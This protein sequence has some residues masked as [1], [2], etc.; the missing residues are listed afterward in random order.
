MDRTI[1]RVLRGVCA[2]AAAAVLMAATGCATIHHGPRQR[3]VIT[4]EPSGADVYVNDRRAGVTPLSVKLWRLKSQVLTIEKPGLE[5]AVVPLKRSAS[6]WLLADV[7][8]SLNPVIGQGM[9]DP[10]PYPLTAVGPLV[11]MLGVDLLT[12]AAFTLPPHIHVTLCPRGESEA[13]RCLPTR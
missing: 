2:M 4:S 9:T 10:P 6:K 13:G 11:G 3:V 5:P 12:G 8:V 7:A 1:D